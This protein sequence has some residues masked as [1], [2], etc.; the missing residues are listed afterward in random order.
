MSTG[1]ARTEVP[2]FFSCCSIESWQT[3]LY[4]LG[5]PKL[6]PRKAQLALH[7]TMA[8]TVTKEKRSEIMSRIRSKN[9]RPEMIVRKLL[10]SA[11]YRYRLHRKDLPGK[12]D[13]VLPK[14]RTVIFVHGCFWHQH[15]GCP[16]A[17]TP[18][19][20]IG[21]WAGKL[22]SN[23]QRDAE[24]VATLLKAGWRVLVVWECASKSEKLAPAMFSFLDNRSS[25]FSEI[26]FADL[27]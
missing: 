24:S 5:I 13:L 9:T 22:A 23:T 12:P 4:V 21:Y 6:K 10:H 2:L 27:S 19:S 16:F 8:D 17:A 1:K 18:K 20:N 11:G 25:I 15:K 3:S 14:Y 26:G 7:A